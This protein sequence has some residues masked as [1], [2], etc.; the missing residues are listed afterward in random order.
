MNPD[1]NQNCAIVS[2]L[3]KRAGA[4]YFFAMP[5]AKS[6]TTTER[7]DLALPELPKGPQFSKQDLWRG[8][9]G[10][11]ICATIT[12]NN[13]ENK[14]LSAWAYNIAVGCNHGCRFCYVPE[15]TR[16]LEKPLRKYGVDDPDEE[17]GQYVLLRAWD[18]KE[19][20][21]SLKAAEE[22]TAAYLKKEQPD[23]NRAVIFCS[24]TDPYQTLKTEEA[25]KTKRLNA[26][27]RLLVQR[28]LEL[29]LEH[30]TINVRILT[31]SPLAIEDFDLYKRFGHRLLFGMSLPT[32]NDG[33]RELY[34][35]GAPGVQK[36]FEVLEK[37]KKQGLNVYVAMAPTSPECDEEDMKATLKAIATLKPVTVFHEPINLRA[38]NVGRIDSHAQKLK[39]AGK[40]KV[41]FR[42]GT[43]NDD[44]LTAYQLWQLQ[45]VE[46]LANEVGL[47]KVLKLW[48]DSALGVR[49]NWELAMRESGL[50]ISNR[51]FE[52][53]LAWCQKWWNLVSDWPKGRKSP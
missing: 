47:G 13:F 51:A 41:K 7:R 20:L 18:E 11:E 17:W 3:P 46:R 44:N 33:I 9:D 19:F 16:K 23:G 50:L 10:E 27:R 49:K 43:F 45:T 48:P 38:D 36:R 32:L 37:A 25:E 21:K 29:I 2:E 12:E 24:T 15:F 34:E 30:S 6:A 4:R 8:G 35:P 22:T 28:A 26:H 40:L 14:S 31:R 52:A 42:T 1:A 39:A 53:H 5:P